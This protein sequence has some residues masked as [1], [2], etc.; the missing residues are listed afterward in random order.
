[1]S[2][3][4]LVACL[5]AGALCL[6]LAPEKPA[7]AAPVAPAGVERVLVRMIEAVKAQSYDDFLTDADA[8]LKSNLSRQQFEG[9]CGLYTAPLRKGYRFEYLGQ[10]RQRGMPV[11]LW[12]IAVVDGQDEALI[13]LVMKDGKAYGFAVH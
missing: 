7:L 12:K 6:T 5:V 13:R 11:Y 2:M 4:N 3:R 1:M 10:L 8:Q 9:L